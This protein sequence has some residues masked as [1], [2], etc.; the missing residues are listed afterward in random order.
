[1]YY[2]EA[3]ASVFDSDVQSIGGLAR[4]VMFAAGDDTRLA[5]NPGRSLDVFK[6]GCARM[7]TS[8][9][10]RFSEFVKLAARCE[11]PIERDLLAALLSD[12]FADEFELKLQ[13][14]A[15]NRRIDIALFDLRSKY[16]LAI[17]CDGADYHTDA[18]AEL[19]RDGELIAHGFVPIHVRGSDI[20]AKPIGCSNA[21]FSI[22]YGL[23]EWGYGE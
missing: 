18:V 9:E 16:K 4:S 15:G 19:R 14:P 5:A 7:T 22:V 8:T 23:R 2:V 20:A 12:D 3:S 17:E 6:R 1:M 21:I 11:S 10:S 13:H